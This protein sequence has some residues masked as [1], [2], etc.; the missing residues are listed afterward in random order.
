MQNID[1]EYLNFRRGYLLTSLQLECPFIH[2]TEKINEDYFLYYHP[3]LVFTK[4]SDHETSLILLGD[5]FDSED[6]KASNESILKQI[7][8]NDFDS[9][10]VSTF[11]YMGRFVLIYSGPEGIKL[12]H[13][14]ASLRK[15][16]YTTKENHHVSASNPHLLAKALGIDKSTNS[17]WIEFYQSKEFMKL[18]NSN[19]GFY[20]IYDEIR[21]VLPNHYYDIKNNK[22]VRFW[23]NEVIKKIDDQKIVSISA[24]MI[25]GFISAAAHRYQ[26]MLPITSGYDSRIIYAATK[27]IES[28]IYYYM[29]NFPDELINKQDLLIPE[30]MLGSHHRKFNLIPYDFPVDEQFKTAYYN[31]NPLPYELFLPVLNNYLENFPDMIN[32]PGGFI[33][34][35]K[36]LYDVDIKEISG[37]KL[38]RLYEVDRFSCAVEFYNKWLANSKQLC[39]NY[40]INVCDLL[41]WEDRVCNW[42]TQLTQD[43]DIAQDELYVFNSQLLMI[44]ML[45][46]TRNKRKKPYYELHKKLVN[47]LWPE[48]NKFPYN[49][50]FKDTLQRNLI[51]A[52]L[53]KPIKSI[54]NKLKG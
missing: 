13:D 29:I 19:I 18:F 50:S 17:C 45:N 16:F 31:N 14:A 12:F 52:G 38:A 7:I 22:I 26:L 51:K 35:I 39:D 4:V 8:S 9:I 27:D 6:Q 25:K 48:L 41:Y 43:K 15:I 36:S 20:T 44:T 37:V 33:P 54:L 23:P 30:K 10:V 11:K 49:P 5:L 47:E 3:D 40:S 28:K 2:K 42:G 1:Y 21:Q 32:L 46:Y 24:R 53:Y 34:L